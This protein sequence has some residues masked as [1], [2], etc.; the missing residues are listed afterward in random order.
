[1]SNFGSTVSNSMLYISSSQ[2]YGKERRGLKLFGGRRLHQQKYLFPL[3]AKPP[4]R[5][6]LSGET[7][8]KVQ[9][10]KKTLNPELAM[11]QT[12]PFHLWVLGDPLVL[13]LPASP[14][15]TTLSY[16]DMFISGV[17]CVLPFLHELLGYHQVPSHQ[18]IPIITKMC[19]LVSH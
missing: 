14:E 11:V 1:M 2:I 19:N 15:K 13:S 18:A 8:E 7:L 5:P 6:L 17:R 16:N 10:R 12:L 3:G 4:S 9:M